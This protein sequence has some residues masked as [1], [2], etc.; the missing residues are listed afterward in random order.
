VWPP[1]TRC[2]CEAHSALELSIGKTGGGSK[3][4]GPKKRIPLE[5][6]EG[7][8]IFPIKKRLR[9]IR[10]TMEPTAGKTRPEFEIS[11][12]KIHVLVKLNLEKFRESAEP[13]L[14][15]GGGPMEPSPMEAGM[16]SKGRLLA[17]HA[18]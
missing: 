3:G 18:A 15:K 17:D 4:R 7:E 13:R 1:S 2:L 6:L 16:R 8:E 12:R 5:D 11:S 9:K 10:H 14:L